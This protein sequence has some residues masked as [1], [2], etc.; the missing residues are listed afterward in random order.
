MHVTADPGAV[1][2]VMEDSDPDLMRDTSGL[3]SIGASNGFNCLPLAETLS[4]ERPRFRESHCIAANAPCLNQ[5]GQRRLQLWWLKTKAALC[6][7]KLLRV[8]VFK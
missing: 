2:N 3:G 6:E 4:N 8:H 1:D 7:K 5:C